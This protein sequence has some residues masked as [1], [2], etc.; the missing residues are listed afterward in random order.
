MRVGA[1]GK[2]VT[3]FDI[4]RA[5][6]LGADWCNSARGFMFALGCIQSQSCHTNRCPVGVA[7]PGPAAPARAGGAGQ[8]ASGSHDFH[9][10]TLKALAEIAGA[11]G[12]EDPS[13]F[14]PYHFMFRQRDGAFEDGNEVFPYL[15]KGFLLSGE[16]PEDLFEWHERWGRASAE[17]FAPMQI[18][19]G[20][21]RHRG[22]A[23]Q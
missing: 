9:A 6:A 14:L 5:L 22:Q 19:E 13:H 21:F 17:S 8:G 16:H 11:A 18:F 7:T 4:A 2:I 12:L 10:N 15:P 3:G 20:H 23:A 1:A